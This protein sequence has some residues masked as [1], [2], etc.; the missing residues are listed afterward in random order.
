[1]STSIPLPPE[2]LTIVIQHLA[3]EHDT[4]TLATLLRVNHYFCSVTLPI[5]YQNP[6][7]IIVPLPGY[8]RRPAFLF[9][10]LK[11][12]QVLLLS[13]P[14]QC[15]ISD[16]LRIAYLSDNLDFAPEH[17]DDQEGDDQ[18]SSSTE[19]LLPYYSFISEISFQGCTTPR[20][21]L[22]RN[23]FLNSNQA[24]RDYLENRPIDPDLIFWGTRF[25]ILAED[26]GRELRRDLTWALCCA[27]AKHI[28]S[29]VIPLYDIDRH[30][31]AVQHFEALADVIFLLDS[32]YKP[33]NMSSSE[34]EG[35]RLF[36]QSK[37]TKCLEKMILF[38]QEHQRI[39]G[40]TLRTAQ[41]RGSNEDENIPEEFKQQLFQL[42][43]PLK[44][45]RF[46]DASNWD[47][48][49]AKFQETNLSFVQLISPDLDG[50][51]DAVMERLVKQGPFL[52]RCRSLDAFIMDS[53]DDDMFQWAV[54]ERRIYDTEVAAGRTPHTSLVPLRLINVSYYHKSFGSQLNDVV[55]AFDKTLEII[56]TSC[57]WQP[58][59]INTQ[60]PPEFVV[61][62]SF[63][64]WNLPKLRRLNLSSHCYPIFL[65]IAPDLISRLPQL[66]YLTLTDKRRRYR[67]SEIVCWHAAS[68][69]DLE[70]LRMEGTPAIS[71][72]PETLRTARNL[73]RMEFRMVNTSLGPYPHVPPAQELEEC[74]GEPINNN[75]RT[76]STVTNA[77]TT[78][79]SM[80]PTKRPIWTWD[81]NL[82]MLTSLFLNAQFAYT[83]QFRMLARTPNL[84]SI[85][86]DSRSYSRLHQRTIILSDFLVPGFDHPSLAT[87]QDK[88]RQ[89]HKEYASENNEDNSHVDGGFHALNNY[90]AQEW[91]AGQ[92]DTQEEEIEMWFSKFDYVELPAL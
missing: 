45:P 85:V 2:C 89:F 60:E 13:L 25:D 76:T 59:D 5:L 34:E 72:N 69:V 51:D 55:F 78:T 62:N 8:Q 86:V 30:L 81:W 40:P 57:Y 74:F 54:D 90:F 36:Q 68:L 1:M 79:P 24:F 58:R 21:G 3:D 22:F 28:K 35:V 65:R 11:L 29:M 82:P 77:T 75:M 39:H 44:D 91:T 37:R 92:D 46:L 53:V 15:T 18:P 47:H 42:L 31:S 27:N 52:H 49:L 71:F 70:E 19:S 38:I 12:T 7:K 66:T 20:I 17:D 4:T 23:H 41:H 14:R 9:N 48:F 6:F 88:E 73:V 80:S 87:M 56:T 33:G 32:Q 16:G 43:R 63:A 50:G 61:G 64:S 10:L 26:A 67:L 83:F 84:N